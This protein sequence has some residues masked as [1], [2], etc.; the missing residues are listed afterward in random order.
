[1]FLL[2]S[3]VFCLIYL[4]YGSIVAL[5][6]SAQH[7]IQDQRDEDTLDF[8]KSC[9]SNWMSAPLCPIKREGDK[10]IC[11][12][13][14]HYYLT[15]KMISPYTKFEVKYGYDKRW[16]ILHAESGKLLF[17]LDDIKFWRDNRNRANWMQ[18]EDKKYICSG[19][20]HIL[21]TT[22]FAPFYCPNCNRYINN[23][24]R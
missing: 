21:E 15:T 8:Y 10:L 22:A 7:S 23:H 17:T 3:I 2:T 4:I 13:P 16:G 14:Q 19:C 18:T 9:E 20:G 6:Y 11:T 1:M 5:G 12:A 24:V